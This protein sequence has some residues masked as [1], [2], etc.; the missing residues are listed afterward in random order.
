MPANVAGRRRARIKRECAENEEGMQY[1][2]R[3][4]DERVGVSRTRRKL[5]KALV[6]RGARC[7]S[8]VCVVSST[9]CCTFLRL[10]SEIGRTLVLTWVPAPE[11]RRCRQE[12]GRGRDAGTPARVRRRTTHPPRCLS[13]RPS[14]ALRPALHA[15]QRVLYPPRFSPW[16]LAPYTCCSTINMMCVPLALSPCLADSTLAHRFSSRTSLARSWTF[17]R[18]STARC[19]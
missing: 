15:L 6:R 5:T 2:G 7:S 17:I 3:V 10:C 14:P 12:E 11:T 19:T 18:A 9:V 13:S 16:P 4:S 1:C 8:C